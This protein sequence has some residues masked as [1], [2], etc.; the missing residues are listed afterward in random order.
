MQAVVLVNGKKTHSVSVSDRG[1]QYGDGVWETIAII[2]GKP[3]FLNDHLDR[4]MLGCQAL[5][6]SPPDL[7]VLQDEIQ[8]LSETVN[9]RA[10]LKII[11]TRG[12]GGRGYRADPSIKTTSTRI[13]SLHPWGDHISNYRENGINLQLCKTRLA[14]NPPL[15]GFKHLNRLEQVLASAELNQNQE[16]LMLDFNDHVIEGTMSNV[17]IL[18]KTKH[19][20]TPR[21]DDATGCG[22]KGIMRQKA[23]EWLKN[24]ACTVSE[25]PI[26]IDDVLNAEAVFMSNSIIGLWGVTSFEN[27]TYSIPPFI[28]QFNQYLDSTL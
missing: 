24:E 17:F 28:S 23:M 10:V 14:Y 22:I 27:K 11:I 26:K 25:E 3:Q 12:S 20:K 5:N 15:S 8:H 16:G 4:L 19:I 9:N 2:N 7:T 13:V 18:D 21:L 6:I 1:L